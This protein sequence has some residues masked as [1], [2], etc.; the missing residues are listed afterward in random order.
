MMT[1]AR[2]NMITWLTPAMIV[3][4]ARGIR[5]PNIVCRG[6]APNICEA[7][8]LSVGTCL[9][10]SAARRTPGTMAYRIE[11]MS[12]GTTPMVNSVTA[13]MM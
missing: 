8:T 9:I 1:I 10:P 6:V 5:T 13:G 11:A 4:A 7:S 2:T 12:P 3:L